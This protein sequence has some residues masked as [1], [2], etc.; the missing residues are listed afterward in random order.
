MGT[1]RRSWIAVVAVLGAIGCGNPDSSGPSSSSSTGTTSSSGTTTSST[2]AGSGTT[3]S[4]T[5]TATAT[6]SM[7]AGGA[8]GS[9]PVVEPSGFTCSGAAPHLS[10]DVVP[11]TSANCAISAGCHSAMST[12][13]GVVNMLVGVIAEECNDERFMV[14]PCDPEHSYVIDKL[15]NHNLS[16]CNPQTTMPYNLPML[17]APDI[18]TIYDW[19]CAGAVDN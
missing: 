3:S 14:K 10:T 11:I 17:A 19:I 6:C 13:G 9:G 12:G 7:D 15:T 16:A 18:Q 4:G 2:S 5:T 8:G 1:A